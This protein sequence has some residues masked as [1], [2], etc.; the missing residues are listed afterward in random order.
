MALDLQAGSNL[1]FTAAGR[2]TLM[3]GLIFERQI[4]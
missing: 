4:E 1:P 2:R 3:Q